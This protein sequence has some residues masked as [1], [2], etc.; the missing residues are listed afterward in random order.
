MRWLNEAKIAWMN[1]IEERKKCAEKPTMI[2]T[3][4]IDINEQFG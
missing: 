1:N 3:A 4:R 2:S